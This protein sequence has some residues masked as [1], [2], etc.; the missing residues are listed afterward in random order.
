MVRGRGRRYVR[1]VLE[2]DPGTTLVYPRLSSAEISGKNVPV[3]HV[4]VVID[5]NVGLLGKDSELGTKLG[6]P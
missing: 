6:H 2:L 5:V 4:D 1:E 3:Q